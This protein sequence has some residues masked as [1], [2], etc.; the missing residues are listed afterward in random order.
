MALEIR[1]PFVYRYRDGNKFSSF[2]SGFLFIANTEL[3]TL[4]E[5]IPP[6]QLPRHCEFISNVITVHDSRCLWFVENPSIAALTKLQGTFPRS[7][8]VNGSIAG[9]T[10]CDLESIAQFWDI[11]QSFN[12]REPW[13]CEQPWGMAGVS[14]PLLAPASDGLFSRP[15]WSVDHVFKHIQSVTSVFVQEG[16]FAFVGVRV[17]ES[18]PQLIDQEFHL[19]IRSSA[20]GES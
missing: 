1:H 2:G 13:N 12:S 7:N 10:A 3:P 15:L 14:E 11:F 19:P 16:W 9:Y 20:E 17:K 8:V 18:I 5:S 6:L 4:G